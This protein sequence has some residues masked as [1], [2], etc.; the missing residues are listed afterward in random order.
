MIIRD[1]KRPPRPPISG[2][3]GD[4]FRLSAFFVQQPALFLRRPV[5]CHWRSATVSKVYADPIGYAGLALNGDPE[6]YLKTV[7][8]YK[9]LDS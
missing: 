2:Q 7:T 1:T 9:P 3:T 6:K 4:R 5:L 8:E